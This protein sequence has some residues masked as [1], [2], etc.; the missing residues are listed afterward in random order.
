MKIF[1]DKHLHSSTTSGL[2]NFFNKACK[3]VVFLLEKTSI[4]ENFTLYS[5]KA[6]NVV[7]E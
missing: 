6:K 7:F 1:L 5:L 4:L 3:A 2:I